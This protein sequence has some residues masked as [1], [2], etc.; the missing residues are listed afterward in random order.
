[1]GSYGIGLERI[2]SSAVEL[3]HD[4]DGIVWPV[5]IAPFTAII[6]PINYKDEVKTA[7]DMLYRDLA[8]AGIDT[9]LDDRAERP[10]VKFKDADLIGIPFRI[11]I[12]S[13][14]LREGKVEIF[15]RSARK[16][17]IINIAEVDRVLRAR[18]DIGISQ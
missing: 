15:E 6:T 8:S 1:M 9:L 2:M 17:E 5:S 13:Q 18:R 14:R 3:Y 16:T 7:A 10:G 11:V 4:A 12:G